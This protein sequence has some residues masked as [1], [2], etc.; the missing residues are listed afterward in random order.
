MTACS[1]SA[2]AKKHALP[3]AALGKKKRDNERCQD[4]RNEEKCDETTFVAIIRREQKKLATKQVSF[5]SAFLEMQ[6]EKSIFSRLDQNSGPF[7]LYYAFSLMAVTLAD[8]LA[9]PWRSGPLLPRHISLAT[10]VLLGPLG[11]PADGRVARM[12]SSYST[13]ATPKTAVARRARHPNAFPPIQDC[14]NNATSSAKP[15]QGPPSQSQGLVF[16]GELLAA[17]I[18]PPFTLA[19]WSHALPRNA[20]ARSCGPSL[21]SL[22]L[23]VP[24][25]PGSFVSF[26]CCVFWQ[27]QQARCFLCIWG[28]AGR[29]ALFPFRETGRAGTRCDSSCAGSSDIPRRGKST[30]NSESR[31]FFRPF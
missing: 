8:L 15:R 13:R 14:T 26:V 9:E 28:F 20:Q 19:S 22:L 2:K 4:I 31:G 1:R 3:V 27:V 10:S 7:C 29:P 18:A 24:G 21:H 25:Q 11:V 23:E 5:S 16:A 12:G 6:E 17:L 30:A